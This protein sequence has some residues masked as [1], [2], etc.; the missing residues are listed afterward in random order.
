VTSGTFS[1]TLGIGVGMGYVEP[2]LSKAPQVFDVKIR[3]RNVPGEVV[4]MPFY[5][6][7]S[8]DKVVVLGQEM[9]LRDFRTKYLTVPTHVAARLGRETA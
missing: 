5:Q 8:E 7:R 3:D 6:R 4:K 2:G 9:G 1:P